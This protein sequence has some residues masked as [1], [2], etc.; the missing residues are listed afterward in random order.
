MN[1]P[2][3]HP[4]ASPTALQRR[5]QTVR[6]QSLA[7]AAPLSDADCQVQSMPDASPT[8]WHLAHTTWFFETF[9]LERAEPGFQPHYDDFLYFAVTIAVA[10]Q[11]ADVSVTT[12]SLRRL[13]MRQSLLSFAFNT[14]ILALMINIAA[15]LF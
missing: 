6:D 10:S 7:L 14:A 1:A 8:K 2:A 9:I 15:G 3:T 4:N 5:Y 11:T 12:A 13:V